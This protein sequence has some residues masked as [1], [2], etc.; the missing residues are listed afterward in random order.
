MHIRIFANQ[1]RLLILA[2]MIVLPKFQI[3]TKIQK[4]FELKTKFLYHCM[5]LNL[6]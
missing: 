1:F 2:W 6:W 3:F 4:S 5:D